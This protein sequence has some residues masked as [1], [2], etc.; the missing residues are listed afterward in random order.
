MEHIT[1]NTKGTDARN[2]LS[3]CACGWS[4]SGT[5]LGVRA[6]ATVHRIVFK[7]EHRLWN[8]PKRRTEMPPRGYEG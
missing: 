7:D 4:V 3:K 6:R 5:Y 8:D 1:Q 2:H